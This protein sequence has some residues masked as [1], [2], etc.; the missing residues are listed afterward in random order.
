MFEYQ[1]LRRVCYNCGGE[2]V[3][4]FVPVCPTCGRFVKADNS[5]SF[6]GLGEIIGTNATCKR[7]GPVQ[8][9]FEGWFSQEDFTSGRRRVSCV[10]TEEIGGSS[11]EVLA[12]W[13]TNR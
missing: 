11:H 7:C 10:N 6:N 5:I 1:N 3:A 13:K 8:M 12:V 9:P 4:V 2:G